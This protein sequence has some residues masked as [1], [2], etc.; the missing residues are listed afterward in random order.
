MHSYHTV[1]R[2]LALGAVLIAIGAARASAADT[3]DIVLYAKHATAVQGAWSAVDDPT[4]AGGARLWN[5]DAGAP[6]VRTAAAAPASYFEL[7][8]T[9][10]QGRA[11]HLWIRSQAQNDSWMNDSVYVQF[12]GSLTSAGAP[13]YRIGTTSAAMYSLEKSVGAGESGWGWQ[14][15]GYGLN[16]VG[17]PIYFDGTPQ[18]IRV[19]VREDGISIDQ[20]V[21]SPVTYATIAPGAG[22]NDTTILPETAAAP[23]PEATPAPPPTPTIPDP[24]PAPTPTP[25]TP[26]PT[27]AP[28]SS[29]EELRVLQWNTH[30]GG[31][32]T[33]GIYSPDRIATSA[34]RMNPDVIMFN[35][36]E[37]NDWWGNQDQPEVYKNLLQEKTGKAWDYVFAQEFGQWN[38]SGKGNLILST[39]PI[40]VSERYE[41]VRNADRSVAMATITVAAR[42]ITLIGTH[43]DPYDQA[44]R[45]AQAT[46]VTSWSAAQPENR[47]IAG[48]M[49]AWP[50]QTS[51]A[52]LNTLYYDSW[53]VAAAAGNAIAFAGNS[54]ETKKGRIDYIF[55]S[56]GSLNLAVKSSQVV[57]TR[58]AGGVMP[59]DHRPVLTTF[60][61]R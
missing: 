10:D 60:I 5:P 59:T 35:E 8:F 14:D 61:V 11:Y 25:T 3:G 44:L 38:A 45:L 54:G 31:Y 46:E 36:I 48:D 56:K 49:N 42:D 47:I 30:H 51:I 53:A 39:Y 22:K 58:D 23:A 26:D 24:T 4:A 41:L 2:A 19:Q 40:N 18:T 33:D 32:G 20:I 52:H 9:A 27:P 55:Y 50:D 15:N 1:R 16:V 6:K 7:P 37:R 57:D 13:K 21:L 17:A 43:L 28:S 29:G 12:S 34:A